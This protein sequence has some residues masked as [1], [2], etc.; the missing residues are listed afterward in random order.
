MNWKSSLLGQTPE[1]LRVTV[2]SKDETYTEVAVSGLQVGIVFTCSYT[3]Q[4]YLWRA[5]FFVAKKSRSQLK[6]CF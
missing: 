6:K 3:F 5:N 1:Q 4:Y 2:V